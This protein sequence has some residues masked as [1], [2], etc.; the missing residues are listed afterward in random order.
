MDGRKDV[1][2]WVL[3]SITRKK[4]RREEGGRSGKTA[5]RQRRGQG[6]RDE[7]TAEHSKGGPGPGGYAGGEQG[8][9]SNNATMAERE[10]LGNGGKRL[11]SQRAG[12]SGTVSEVALVGGG[13]V[14]PRGV[15]RP[16]ADALRAVEGNLPRRRAREDH[17]LGRLARD[18]LST[19]DG[20]AVLTLSRRGATATRV[21]LLGRVDALEASLADVD[22]R[23]LVGVREVL[24]DS[25]AVG[26]E[27]RERKVSFDVRKKK[28]K[29]KIERTWNQRWG[30]Q[31][32]CRGREY[33]EQRS[34]SSWREQPG[35][36]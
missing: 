33:G 29:K 35:K 27:R 9:G 22:A 3:L 28:K 14:R 1:E 7:Q 20:G 34:C 5:T 31:S 2:Q 12:V 10:R 21:E 4:G 6:I 25:G 26:A 8:G 18:A 17:A 30:T 13:V 36:D 15:V 16:S 24:S 19:T 23:V 32:P 11:Q